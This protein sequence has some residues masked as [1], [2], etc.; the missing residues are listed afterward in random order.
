LFDNNISH[1]SINAGGLFVPRVNGAM[2]FCLYLPGI[3][4]IDWTCCQEKPAMHEKVQMELLFEVFA[5][6][7]PR[8]GPGDDASTVKALKILLSAGLQASEG[9]RILELGCGNGAPTM[10][11]ARNLDGAILALDFHEP[12]LDELNRRAQAEG[13]SGKIRTLLADMNNLDFEKESFD[14]IWS[15]GALY[16]MGFRDGLP[17]CR[18]LLSPG[19]M[20]AVTEL[21]YFTPE[22]P[23][24]CRAFFD[25]C[26][27]P[28]TDV[29][30]N[31]AYIEDAG[32]TVLDH[33]ALPESSWL[34]NYL[35]PLEKR[36]DQVEGKYADSPEKMEMLAWFRMEIDIYRKYSKHY[37]YEFFMMKK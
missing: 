21:V 35:I 37:G 30:T 28:M 19:G 4:F 2:S 11:L 33:F 18:S 36:L 22:V 9:L 13:F 23:Q 10:Q 6:S 3:R 31:L 14:L 15:E 8:L 20:M 27:P 24:E 12:F 16:N 34:E 1:S 26:Y 5:A 7:M 25:E 29:K 32:F 17:V